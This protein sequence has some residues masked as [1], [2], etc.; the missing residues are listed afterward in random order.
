[1]IYLQKKVTNSK[2]STKYRVAHGNVHAVRNGQYDV[3]CLPMG[4]RLINALKAVHGFVERKE[5][6]IYKAVSSPIESK[7]EKKE[8]IITSAKKVTRKKKS[9]SSRSL[10]VDKK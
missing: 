9:K 8:K 10:S 3:V 6:A 1:M 5:K 2:A 4:S 7:A